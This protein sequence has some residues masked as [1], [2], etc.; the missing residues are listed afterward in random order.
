[1]LDRCG[2]VAVGVAAGDEA[3]PHRCEAVLPAGEPPDAADV[4]EDDQPAFAFEYAAGFG[5]GMVRVGDG[6][7]HKREDHGVEAAVRVWQRFGGGVRYLDLRPECPVVLT[8]TA[9]VRT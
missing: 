7:E 1:M 4:F 5:E 3:S 8:S 2:G 9:D 6:A